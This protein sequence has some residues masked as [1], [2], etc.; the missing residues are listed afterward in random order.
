MPNHQDM[1]TPRYVYPRLSPYDFA[2]FRM[3]GAGLAN[4]MFVAARAFINAQQRGLPLIAPTWLR[5][6]I[7]QF[8]RGDR[9][10]RVY[11]NLFFNCGITGLRKAYLLTFARKHLLSYKGNGPHFVD[12]EPHHEL[13]QDY[14]NQITRPETIALVPSK[15]QLADCVA[16][17]VRLGDYM[18]SWRIPI[19]WF[20]G[21]ISNALKLNPNQRFLIFSDGS[22]EE[23][24]PLTSLPNTKR[25]FY[26]NAY[27]DMIAISRCKMLVASD[28]TFSCWGAFLG[29]VPS[30]FCRRN[31]PSVFSGHVPEEVIG[32][33]TEL[34]QAFKEII[35]QT[36]YA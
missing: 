18:A 15:E 3:G 4:C 33:S 24:T 8:L 22:D 32:N 10:K 7:G 5:L 26:G 13:I 9:D 25:V 29:R 35:A 6:S 31:F 36:S 12:L 30:L 34:P 21:V 27:A 14:F 11:S 19:D 16:V 17:H 2:Y 20:V 28:S 1:P 23:L